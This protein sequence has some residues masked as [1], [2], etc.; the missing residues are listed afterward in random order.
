MMRHQLILKSVLKT[1]SVKRVVGLGSKFLLLMACSKESED[2]T[3]TG[4]LCCYRRTTTSATPEGTTDKAA[5]ADSRWCEHE[6]LYTSGTYTPGTQSTT[7]TTSSMV[8]KVGGSV[9]P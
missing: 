2:L 3:P 1:L 4:T 5:N 8:T 9:G 7:F 6:R